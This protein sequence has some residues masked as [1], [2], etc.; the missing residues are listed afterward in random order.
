MASDPVP[1]LK[2]LALALD[3]QGQVAQAPEPAPRAVSLG[4]PVAV[5]SRN[6]LAV[7]VE[8]ARN[9]NERNR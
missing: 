5:Q 6:T 9:A 4:G 3:G 2:D 7:L 1:A 8:K